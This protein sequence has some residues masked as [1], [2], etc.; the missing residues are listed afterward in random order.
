MYLIK[1]PFL[2]RAFYPSCVWRKPNNEKLIYL[3]FDDGP[4][5]EI[6]PWI[7][8]QLRTHHAKATFFCIGNN[9]EKHP[10]IFEKVINGGHSLGNHTFNHLNGWKTSTKEYIENSSQ[11]LVVSDFCHWYVDMTALPFPLPFSR[12][13]QSHKIGRAHV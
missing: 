9:I 7:L 2:L 3:S 4:H 11:W 13:E 1:T 8:E 5:P 10:T 6:T 12:A